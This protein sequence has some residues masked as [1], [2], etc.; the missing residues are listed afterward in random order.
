VKVLEL[1]TDDLASDIEPSTCGI[2]D[3]AIA[4]FEEFGIRRTSIAEIAK[5]AGVHR[6]T[7]YRRFPS[8]DELVLA[9]TILWTRRFFAQ[10]SDAVAHLP[11]DAERLVEGFVV[12]HRTL[13]RDAFVTRML[14][15]E[16]DIA[17]PFLTVDGGPVIAALRDFLVSQ[18]HATGKDRD[19]IIATA[20]LAARIGLSLLLTPQSHFQLD[21]DRRRRAFARRYLL[22][23]AADPTNSR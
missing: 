14:T 7:V 9:A 19:D 4:E 22:H 16:R 15:T 2:L 10:I 12:A 23:T 21:T 5:R 3:A 8:K 13:L 6:A 17:L 11:T 18:T 1:L 20:E